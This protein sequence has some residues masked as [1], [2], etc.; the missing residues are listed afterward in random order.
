MLIN[1]YIS[2]RKPIP[3]SGNPWDGHTLEWAAASPPVHHNFTWLPPVRSERPMW[4]FNHPEHT[5]LVHQ[6]AEA[7]T[8][9]DPEAIGTALHQDISQEPH[10]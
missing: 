8:P 2:W 7:G 6:K 9:E 5:T 4:D 3:A 1:F 10:P